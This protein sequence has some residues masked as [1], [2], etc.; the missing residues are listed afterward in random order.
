MDKLDFFSNSN[1]NIQKV[2][3]VLGLYKYLESLEGKIRDGIF[4]FTLIHIYKRCLKYS[5]IYISMHFQL[6]TCLKYKSSILLRQLQWILNSNSIFNSTLYLPLLVLGSI[7]CKCIFPLP[8][9]FYVFEIVS[10]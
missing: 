7:P 10:C 9:I 6:C 3:F 2:L 8:F 1:R 4:F 5:S